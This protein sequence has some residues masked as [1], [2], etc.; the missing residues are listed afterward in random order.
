VSA[1]EWHPLGYD[2][3]GRTTGWA[4]GKPMAPR[5]VGRVLDRLD[6]YAEAAESS[7]TDAGATGDESTDSDS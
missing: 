6:A 3:T 2:Y 5:N 1:V 7:D 4:Y